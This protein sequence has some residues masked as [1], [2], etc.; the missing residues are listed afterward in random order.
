MNHQPQN[1]T[2]FEKE[3]ELGAKLLAFTYLAVVVLG[4][5]LTTK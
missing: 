1:Q 2:P 3:S 5:I 4:V